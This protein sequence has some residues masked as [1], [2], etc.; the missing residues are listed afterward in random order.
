MTPGKRKR[1]TGPKP[2]HPP[3]VDKFTQ[4]GEAVIFGPLPPGV[5]SAPGPAQHSPKAGETER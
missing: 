2:P 5:E 4:P 1:L 3:C